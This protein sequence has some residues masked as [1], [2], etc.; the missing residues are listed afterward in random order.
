MDGYG[1]HRPVFSDHCTF[2]AGEGWKGRPGWRCGS[3][4]SADR[5]VRLF[6]IRVYASISGLP[7][8]S[9]IASCGDSGCRSAHRRRSDP[10]GAVCSPV[11]LCVARGP[12][13][14]SRPI[15]G[16]WKVPA[17]R[18]E[19]DASS[20]RC[21]RYSWK[22][23]NAS[24]SWLSRQQTTSIRPKVATRPPEPESARLCRKSRRQPRMFARIFWS[25]ARIPTGRDTR[26]APRGPARGAIKFE[27]PI[28][29]PGA[30]RLRG[31]V[32]TAP[33]ERRGG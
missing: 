9:V 5:S 11:L 27:L 26:R 30:L 2:C 22:P 31:P 25:R 23:T 28:H 19:T 3:A 33:G 18:S 15:R 1:F 12:L 10:A 17:T 21:G 24:D 8:D 14:H 7:V 4:M 13:I 6:I 29:D 16:L 20:H 32:E